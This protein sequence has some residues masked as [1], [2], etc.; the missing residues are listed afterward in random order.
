MTKRPSSVKRNPVLLNGRSSSFGH[1]WKP[2]NDIVPR[3]GNP[4]IMRGTR[5]SCPPTTTK[6]AR[7]TDRSTTRRWRNGCIS[8]RDGSEGTEGR[9]LTWAIGFNG[10]KHPHIHASSND[11]LYFYLI[12]DGPVHTS[13][14]QDCKCERCAVELGV[15]A[16]RMQDETATEPY[17]SSMPRKVLSTPSV[18]SDTVARSPACPQGAANLEARPP[19]LL[20]GYAS[21]TRDVSSSLDR[22]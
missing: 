14:R 2:S 16:M 20:R 17:F 19:L 21:C 18:G 5:T 7:R 22:V 8:T 1:R 11:M 15:C 9:L 6:A 3:L 13:T 10:R 12:S 4:P